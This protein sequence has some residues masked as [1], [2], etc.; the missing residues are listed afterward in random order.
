[1]CTVMFL[2]SATKFTMVS[3]RDE[4]TGRP[5]ASAP[6]I[7]IE[8]DTKLIY[9]KDAAA[10]GTWAGANECGH[11]LVLLN[12]AFENHVKEKKYRKSRGLIVKEMLSTT[13]PVSYWHQLDLIQIE[14]FTI[15]VFENEKLNELVW[16]GNN[17]HHFLH[18]TSQAHIWSS[19]TLY[20]DEAKEKRRNWFQHGIS[21]HLLTDTVQIHSFL[22]AH[23][24]AQIGFVMNRQT[25]LATL[26][27]SIIEQ[28][29]EVI[30]FNYL[31]LRN[32]SN[33]VKRLSTVTQ[34][35]S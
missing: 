18:D 14:P 5:A 32:A 17:K 1:M 35:K 11:V 26:S 2:P 30:T 10:G 6:A 7:S 21:N 31:D 24:N 34:I 15:I 3:C 4:D 29:K 28:Q 20:D 22:Q 16:D 19:A 13:H 23:D 25:N 9:P 27:I 8:K 33:V 12:G